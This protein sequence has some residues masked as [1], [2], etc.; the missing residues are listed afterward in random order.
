MCDIYSYIYYVLSRSLQKFANEFYVDTTAN[1][2][3]DVIGAV[4]AVGINSICY[5]KGYAISMKSHPIVTSQS[6]FHNSKEFPSRLKSQKCCKPIGTLHKSER[7]FGCDICNLNCVGTPMES[8][9]VAT[10]QSN[11]TN[12]EDFMLL[13]N[14]FVMVYEPYFASMES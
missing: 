14:R 5:C 3:P 9:Q 11:C 12:S 10:S 7:L 2:K 8:R 1:K 4:Q 13:E 6:N